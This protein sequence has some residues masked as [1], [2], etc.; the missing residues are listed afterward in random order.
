MARRSDHTRDELKKL[1]IESAREIIADKGLM[2]LTAREIA[3]KI[4]YSAGTIYNVFSNL[5]EIIYH[6]EVEVLEALEDFL[7]DSPEGLSS[8]EQLLHFTESYLNFI[9]A[10]YNSWQLL[11][12]H[13][14]PNDMQ[15]PGWYKEKFS[16][17]ITLVEMR[18]RP[19]YPDGNSENVQRSARVFWAGLHGIIMFSGPDKLSITDGENRKEYAMFWV[20]TYIDGLV[21]ANKVKTQTTADDKAGRPATGT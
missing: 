2:G 9:D 3:G 10:H 16:R 5:N 7:V 15:I 6:L 18:I 13:K 4:R 11:I 19:L 14:A 12:E 20:K 1:M 8:G 17:I 21:A